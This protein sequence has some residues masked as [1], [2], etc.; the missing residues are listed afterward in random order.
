MLFVEVCGEM[1]HWES[2]HG[3]DR[4]R[5]EALRAHLLSRGVNRPL[6]CHIRPIFA[7]PKEPREFVYDQMAAASQADRS[8]KLGM[9]F[10][11][12]DDDVKAKAVSEAGYDADQVWRLAPGQDD[13][14]EDELDASLTLKEFDVTIWFDRGDVDD[15][16]Q[17]ITLPWLN[18]CD[19]DEEDD[20]EDGDLTEKLLRLSFE[21]MQWQ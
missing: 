7:L 14:Q 9:L 6:Q 4:A 13:L 17:G 1:L 12:L 3:D 20:D 18:I 16:Y 5:H 15:G 11:Q 2:L 8:A 21:C 10:H 19:E